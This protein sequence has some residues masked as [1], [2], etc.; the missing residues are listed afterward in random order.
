MA[1]K[2]IFNG[3][4]KYDSVKLIFQG[5]KYLVHTHIMQTRIF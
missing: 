3:K 2:A 1:E 5:Y 4:V